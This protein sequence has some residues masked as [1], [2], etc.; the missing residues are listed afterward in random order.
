MFIYTILGTAY[1]YIYQNTG[2]RLRDIEIFNDYM[3]D[4]IFY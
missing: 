4:V 1:N 2:N 3:M